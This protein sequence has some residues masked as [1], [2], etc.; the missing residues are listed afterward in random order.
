M[1]RIEMERV[2]AERY[3]AAIEWVLNDAKYKAPEQVTEECLV[4]LD[5]LRA[6]VSAPEEQNP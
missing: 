5:R 2:R 3:K 1:A 4:W 6:A